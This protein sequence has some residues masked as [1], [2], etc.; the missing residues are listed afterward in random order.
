MW[1]K[2][3]IAWSLAATKGH[4]EDK[5]VDSTGGVNHMVDTVQCFFL[6]F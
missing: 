1:K 2:H 4:G 5:T 3:T 6:T